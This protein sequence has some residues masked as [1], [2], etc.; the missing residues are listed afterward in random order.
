MHKSDWDKL[1]LVGFILRQYV[2]SLAI[3]ALIDA[4]LTTGFIIATCLNA[5]DLLA[6][7]IKRMMLR[8]CYEV[9]QNGGVVYG[10]RGPEP[11]TTV[12]GREIRIPTAYHSTV[13]G[14]D[15]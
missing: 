4:P 6:R 15:L 3:C 1:M 14:A 8:H 10:P 5:S 2:T 12:R 11:V 9:W 7:W 13:K